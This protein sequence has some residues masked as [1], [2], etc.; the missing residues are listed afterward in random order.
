MP[1]SEI[2]LFYSWHKHFACS[3]RPVANIVVLLNN[4]SDT[5]EPNKAN[6]QLQSLAFSGVEVI[7]NRLLL[8]NNGSK[9]TIVRASF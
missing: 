5:P 4:T 8:V 7:E 6:A 1:D 2:I 9:Q 3:L